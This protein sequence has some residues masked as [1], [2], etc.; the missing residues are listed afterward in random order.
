[1]GG[2]VWKEVPNSMNSVPSENLNKTEMS[3]K[4]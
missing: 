4:C 2:G 1:V 3:M